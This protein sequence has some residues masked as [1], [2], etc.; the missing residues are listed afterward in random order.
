MIAATNTYHLAKKPASGGMPAS[1]NS[2]MAK[3]NASSG[4]VRDRPAKS[5]ICSIGWPSRLIDRITA[6]VPSVIAT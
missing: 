2:S 3:K 4:L 5:L 6:K 1:E